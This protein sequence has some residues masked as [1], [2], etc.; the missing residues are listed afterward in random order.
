MSGYDKEQSTLDLGSD[1]DFL[2]KPF[3]PVEL[4]KLLGVVSGNGSAIGRK[5]VRQLLA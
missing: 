3:S 5:E 1:V 2:P 4:L